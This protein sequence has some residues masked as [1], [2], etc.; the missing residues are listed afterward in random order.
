MSLKYAVLWPLARIKADPW[1]SAMSASAVAIA[2]F[3]VVSLTSFVKEVET[4]VETELQGLGYDLLITAR[5]CPYEAATLMLRGG[6]GMRY[7]PAGVQNTVQEDDAIAASFPILLHPVRDTSSD[8]GMMILRGMETAA[9]AAN[10]L[11]FMAGEAFEKQEWGVVLGFEAAEL[12]QRT[13]GSSFLLPGTL[14]VEPREVPVV[15]VLARSGTQIDGSVMLPIEPMQAHFQLEGRLTGIGVQLSPDGR[16]S[17]EGII[18]RYESDPELQVVQLSAVAAR[19]RASTND[20]SSLAISLSS[21]VAGIAFLLLFAVGFLRTDS[22]KQQVHVLHA[23]GLSSGFLL[24]SSAVETA[25]VVG[26]GVVLGAA[27]A[28][29]AGMHL[30][31]AFEGALPFVPDS[32]ELGL[33]RSD[34]WI[35][36][37]VLMAT[38]VFSALPQW[39]ALRRSSPS[40]LRRS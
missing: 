4:A 40:D 32:L 17:Q 35:A 29:A 1:V 11:S 26:A 16:S 15:G 22:H 34:A 5:G 37:A 39:W 13:V 18:K 6:V 2:A 21:A 28:A 12:D 25:L 7:M 33:N 30:L 27:L 3:V 10:G 9:F 31:G 24:L 23:S 36:L 19:L 14:D 8:S 38:S 20:M